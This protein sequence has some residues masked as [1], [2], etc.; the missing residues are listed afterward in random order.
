M[1]VLFG[2]FL[3]AAVVGVVVSAIGCFLA[4]LIK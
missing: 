2:Y 4:D 1:R 3:V